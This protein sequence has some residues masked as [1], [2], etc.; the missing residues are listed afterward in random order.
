M[1]SAC[2]VLAGLTLD[3]LS[4]SDSTHV[5]TKTPQQMKQRTDG[6]AWPVTGE[7]TLELTKPLLTMHSE[8]Q[9]HSRD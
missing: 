1:Q 3:K 2:P 6:W 9:L 5:T 7:R 8:Y 4:Q